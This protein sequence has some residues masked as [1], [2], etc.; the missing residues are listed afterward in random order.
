M[1]ARLLTSAKAQMAAGEYYEAHQRL[2]TLANRYMKAVGQEE[3]TQADP[4]V[5]VSQT[6]DLLVEGART[7]LEHN[8][9]SSAADLI[10]YVLDIY[11]RSA[12]W[13]RY[14]ADKQRL[15]VL[16]MQMPAS[17]PQRPRLLKG[18]LNWSTKGSTWKLP[19]YL[20][21]GDPDLH[22][23]L[24]TR[25]AQ[26]RL[27]EAA[28]AHLLLGIHDSAPR[29]AQLMHTWAAQSTTAMPD[30]PMADSGLFA[31]RAVLPYLALHKPNSAS[32]FM[33]TYL[34]ENPPHDASASNGGGPGGALANDPLAQYQTLASSPMA[35][36]CQ[37]L[38]LAVERQAKEVFLKLRR[39]YPVQWGASSEA[40]NQ[41]L[42]IIGETYFNISIPKQSNPFQDIMQALFA[43]GGSNK[44]SL[45]PS[46][47]PGLD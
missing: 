7:F 34:A 2:R 25:L 15:T 6:I 4:P 47:G 10:A 19:A 20:S 31:A 32:Y 17:E 42:D 13:T 8:Q 3:S 38:L 29:L 5:K 22:H 30:E 12:W 18:L 35:H 40:A 37:L 27:F 24:G 16:L 14:A 33:E 45:L 44:P 1:S 9:T 11:G 36:F 39:E 43:P 28:E 21:A 46:G 23:L 41:L 26:D